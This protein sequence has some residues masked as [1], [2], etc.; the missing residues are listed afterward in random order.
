MKEPLL[1]SS[2]WIPTPHDSIGISRQGFLGAEERES[3]VVAARDGGIMQRLV[4]RANAIV[5]LNRGTNCQEIDAA[6]LIDDGTIQK[7]YR[8]FKQGETSA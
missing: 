8:I 3:L 7:W 1:Y 4:R 6:L 2:D 5:P